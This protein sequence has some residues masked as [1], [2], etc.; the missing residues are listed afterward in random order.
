MVE[1][2]SPPLNPSLLQYHAM[3]ELVLIGELSYC[4]L[5]VIDDYDF[6]S[7]VVVRIGFI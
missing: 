7:Q 5:F 4:C 1:L 2:Q 6:L 3:H